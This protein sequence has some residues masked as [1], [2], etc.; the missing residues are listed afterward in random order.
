MKDNNK[1]NTDEVIWR[2]ENVDSFLKEVF[3]RVKP[4]TDAMTEKQKTENVIKV[5]MSSVDT[6]QKK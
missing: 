2:F 5:I 1:T 3:T 4:Q 6:L